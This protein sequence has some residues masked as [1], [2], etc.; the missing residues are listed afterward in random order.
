MET[1]LITGASGLIGTHLTVQLKEKGYRV[2]HLSRSA[3]K[4]SDVETFEWNV[5]KQTIDEQAV[6]EAD[7]IIH[8][9]GEGITH[10]RWS[11]TQKKEI[12]DSRVKSI[13]LLFNTLQKTNKALKGF[14]SASG[15]GIYGGITTEKIYTEKDSPYSDFLGMVCKKWE[16]AATSISQLGIRVV[17]FRTGVVLWKDGGALK[18]IA[19]PVKFYVG[20]PLGSGRQYVPWIH[21]DDICGLYIKAI[22]D[23]QMQGAYNA[24]A[25]E[26]VTNKTLTKMIARVLHRP[27]IMPNVPGFIL[28]MFLGKMAVVV[29]EGSR[30]SNKKIEHAGY[31]FKFPTLNSALNHLF[32]N[33]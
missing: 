19:M 14:V 4:K 16:E 8:L 22:E 11:E 20:S 25:P 18:K 9:A 31:R 30:V 13:E 26:H 10:H 15:V 23:T 28:K 12:I 2:I 6:K 27:L 3:A 29:L 33:N 7:Y 24:V 21:L 32:R 17:K 1:I 5:E